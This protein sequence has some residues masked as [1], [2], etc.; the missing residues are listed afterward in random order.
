MLKYFTVLTFF[1]D[2]LIFQLSP[3][4]IAEFQN[5]KWDSIIDRIQSSPKK[6]VI[7]AKVREE[8]GRSETDEIVLDLHEEDVKIE[9]LDA[10]TT[11]IR[12]N[13]PAKFYV[14]GLNVICKNK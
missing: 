12:E 9:I 7:R 3:D 14:S 6:I 13:I 2:I 5:F 11:V 10:S 4:G 8:T 1:F